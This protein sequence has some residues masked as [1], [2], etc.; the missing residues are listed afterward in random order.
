MVFDDKSTS[1]IAIQSLE[2]ELAPLSSKVSVTG[3]VEIWLSNLS[4]VMID[5]LSSQLSDC[6]KSDDMNKNVSQIL[7]VAENVHFTI[8]VRKA[9]QAGSLSQV[10][11]SLNARIDELTSF[12]AGDDLVLS[13]KMKALVLDLIHL[14]DIAK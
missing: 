3:P 8:K 10:A 11:D 12:D 7:G 4:S 14:I 5:T 1:I 13:L 9:I 6:I 2:G